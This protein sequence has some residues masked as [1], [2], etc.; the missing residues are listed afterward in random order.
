MDEMTE[1][2]L[3][4]WLLNRGCP[5]KQVDYIIH[6]TDDAESTTITLP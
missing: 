3:Y 4:A 6:Q 5:E 1:Q 2:Q